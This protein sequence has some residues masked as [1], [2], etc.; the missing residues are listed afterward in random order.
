MNLGEVV[1]NTWDIA[2]GKEVRRL[3]ISG[4]TSLDLDMQKAIRTR[5]NTQLG[6]FALTGFLALTPVCC[7]LLGYLAIR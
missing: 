4:M 5:D 2:T 1:K 3:E 6:L 7:S